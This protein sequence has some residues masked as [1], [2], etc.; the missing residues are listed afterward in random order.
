MMSLIGPLQRKSISAGMSA[1]RVSGLV[2]LNASFVARDPQPTSASCAP[3]T[4]RDCHPIE[5]GFAAV[6]FDHVAADEFDQNR[7]LRP[8]SALIRGRKRYDLH[9]VLLAQ[10]AKMKRVPV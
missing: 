5:G 1:I 10:P 2:V 7:R 4:S 6:A 9:S 3:A 8:A